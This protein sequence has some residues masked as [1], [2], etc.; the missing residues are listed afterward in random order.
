MGRVEERERE[1]LAAAG[2]RLHELLAVNALL[3]VVQARKLVDLLF[4][5]LLAGNALVPKVVAV[6]A[7]VALALAALHD[8]SLV[9]DID[10][11]LALGVRAPALEG[12]SFK[13]NVLLELLVLLKG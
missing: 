1:K 7:D 10:D 11:F 3:D 12:V 9:L 5:Q 2:T 8:I 6:D 13:A 4:E